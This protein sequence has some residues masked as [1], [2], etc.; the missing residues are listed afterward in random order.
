MVVDPCG[1]MAPP[2]APLEDD[3]PPPSKLPPLAPFP[4]PPRGT[5]SKGSPGGLLVFGGM[6]GAGGRGTS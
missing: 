5:S 2:T 4:S 6:F 3:P 1:E